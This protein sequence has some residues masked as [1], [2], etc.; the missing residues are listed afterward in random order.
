[1]R[2]SPNNN[3]T[4]YEAFTWT[5]FIAVVVIP[6]TLLSYCNLF[7]MLALRR[8][9]RRRS[10][11]TITSTVSAATRDSH[12]GTTLVLVLFIV[13]HSVLVPPAEV[14]NFF[15]F[16]SAQGHCHTAIQPHRSLFERFA[17]DVLCI[18]LYSVLRNQCAVSSRCHRKLYTVSSAAS[19]TYTHRTFVN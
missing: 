2:G 8:A 17:D 3:N 14:A 15:R 11:I 10:A 6:L 19:H 12:Q 4:A 13:M 16:L 9:A 7:M 18:E 5:Y 1:M